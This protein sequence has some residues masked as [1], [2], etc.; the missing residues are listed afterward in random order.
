[1][2]R[3]QRIGILLSGRPGE[4]E[5]G[6]RQ[7]ESI[8]PAL[9]ARGFESVPLFVD[10]NIDL[11]VR[12]ARIDRAIVALQGRHGGDGC[13]QGFLELIGIPY[14]GSG[15]LAAS[16]GGNRVKTKEVWRL[17]NLPTAAGYIFDASGDERL[18]DRHGSF[19]FPVLVRPVRAAVAGQGAIDQN[20]TSYLAHDEIDLEACVE[21][22]MHVGDEV[23]IERF[24]PGKLVG[25][26]VFDGQ[27]FAPI[28]LAPTLPKK[29]SKRTAAEGRAAVPG[30][31][32]LPKERIRSVLRM[33]TLAYEA[34]G[35]SGAANVTVQVNE[36]GNEILRDI[37][38]APVIT[39][40]SLLVRSAA[41]AGMSMPKLVGKLVDGARLHTAS[42]KDSCRDVP[43]EFSGQDRRRSVLARAH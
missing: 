43:V 7:A 2:D 6:L 18:L 36:N 42:H 41:A 34:L 16:Q 20:P 12:Q 15:V 23:L 3:I 27:P 37:D 13:V 35:C 14:T 4:R 9:G 33:A 24:V 1:M 29:L 11:M 39:P 21:Q 17:H 8:I 28:D 5:L 19:G 32:R 31:A 26:A 25:I 22:A 10:G 38:V 40:A 30:P